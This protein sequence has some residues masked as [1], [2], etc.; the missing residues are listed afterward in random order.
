[1]KLSTVVLLMAE[2]GSPVDRELNSLHQDVL[3][4]FSDVSVLLLQEVKLT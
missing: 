3:N 2:L 1:M 4:P